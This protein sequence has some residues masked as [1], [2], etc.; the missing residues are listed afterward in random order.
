MSEFA[1]KSREMKF[2]HKESSHEA[3]DLATHFFRGTE[4][5]TTSLWLC[6]HLSRRITLF[7][8]IEGEM[9]AKAL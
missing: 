6:D 1:R 9:C 4:S 2:N 8:L 7:H 5:Q 3:N